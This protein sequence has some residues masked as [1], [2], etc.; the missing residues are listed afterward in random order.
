MAVFVA[1]AVFS[2]VA[3]GDARCASHL[4]VDALEGVEDG[5]DGQLASE[6]EVEVLRKPEVG[7]ARLLAAELVEQG[8]VDGGA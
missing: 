6:G 7:S 3:E 4:A 8:C 5:L 1:L 2:G